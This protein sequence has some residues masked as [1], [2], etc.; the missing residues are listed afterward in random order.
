MHSL[1]DEGITIATA[2]MDWVNQGHELRTLIQKGY[3]TMVTTGGGNFLVL[4]QIS[5]VKSVL[6]EVRQ[7]KN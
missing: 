6:S 5:C 4:C 1:N 7:V 2:N 3:D